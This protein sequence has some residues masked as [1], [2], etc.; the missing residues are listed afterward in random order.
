MAD[1]LEWMTAAE[2]RDLVAHKQISPV[3]IVRRTLERIERLDGRFHAFITVCGKEALA[4]AGEAER[5]VMQ[6]DSL[7]PLHGVPVALKDEI[8]TKGVR[9]TA[10][11]LL[12]ENFIPEEDGVCAARLRVAGAICVGKTNVPEF[13]SWSRTANRLAPETVNP[14]DVRRSPGASSGGSGAAVAAGMTPLAVGS[15][16]GGSVRIPSAACGVVGLFPTP[17]RVPDTGS[18]SYGYCGSLGPMGRDV[19]D[20]ATMLAAMSGPDG[21][22]LRSPPA[23]PD[24]LADLDAGVEGMRF[25]FTPDFGYIDVDPGVADAVR[26]S[27]A[28]LERA[29]AHVEEPGL[30]IDD[31]WEWLRDQMYGAAFFGE[32]TPPRVSSREFDEFCRRPENFSRLTEYR[33]RALQLPP[34]TRERY[35]A[36]QRRTEALKASFGK[37]FERYDAIVSPTLP[38]VAPI[39]PEGLGD[40]YPKK[41]CS[42]TYY[43][44][45]AN[46]AELPAASFP[47]GLL[48]GLP[49]GL[50]VIGKPGREDTVLRICRALE[51]V[52]D[53]GPMRPAL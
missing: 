33:Q 39:L 47:C 15:D 21:G 7:G 38:V 20:V 27:I 12:F 18:F 51:R 8:W 19:R 17:G 13:M 3:E 6:G 41:F 11:S 52:L 34:V 2:I 22:D 30:S 50:Q 37:L 32:A 49:V 48:D 44:A 42:G 25:A 40:P 24:F 46:L 43:T 5:A 16:G 31:A 45:A 35:E 29:G 9:A 36:A 14:W 26:S 28:Q 1:E 23:Q 53:R 4:Q 10:G